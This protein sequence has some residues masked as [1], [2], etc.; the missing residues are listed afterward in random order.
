MR[1]ADEGEKSMRIGLCTK[2]D[3]RDRASWSGTYYYIRKALER[4]IGEVEALGPLRNRWL[5]P[6]KVLNKL[7]SLV[8]KRFEYFHSALL[9]HEY[10]RLLEKRLR[11]SS[12]GL[13]VFPAE[14]EL[15]AYLRTEIPIVYISDSTFRLMTD[16]YPAFS[17]LPAFNKRWG[18]EI[19]QRAISRAD[20][21]I[22]S[23][24]WAADSARRDYLCDDSK[25]H[26]LPFGPNLDEVPPR[27]EIMRIRQVH[28][29][30]LKLLFMGVEWER[31]GGEMAFRTMVELNGRGIDTVLTVCGCKPPD[32]FRHEK[33]RV[34]GF[35]DKNRKEDAERLDS[36][37]KDA[38]FLIHPAR[39]ECFAMV[40]AESAAYG[41]PVI[42]TLTGGISSYVR[43]SE[44]GFLLPL[45]APPGHYADKIERTWKN[46]ETYLCL[47]DHGRRLYEEK[48]NWDAWGNAV[49]KAVEPFLK[50]SPPLERERNRE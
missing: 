17:N 49:R 21:L 11:G 35:L 33:L 45:D 7:S 47:S 24:D 10:A 19:E 27:E 41:L 23:S 3:S 6:G 36:L 12:P 46:R 37:M 40:F 28:D 43:E 44:T 32:A 18:E 31:K 30:G 29:G 25:V 1:R 5:I 9:A 50:M 42:T 4:H 14:S 22:Y 8:G 38:T 13:L 34:E 48:L 2:S 15:L 39:A 26:V 16:Y 20:V